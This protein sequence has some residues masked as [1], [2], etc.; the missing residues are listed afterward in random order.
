MSKFLKKASVSAKKRKIK[1]L[2]CLIYGTVWSNMQ[3]KT[4]K[5][6]N[7]EIHTI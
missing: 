5:R 4:F 7:N 1:T 2:P 3:F 6:Q